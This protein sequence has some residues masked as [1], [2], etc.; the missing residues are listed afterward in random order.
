MT[1]EEELEFVKTMLQLAYAYMDPELQRPVLQRHYG[2]II[3]R[4]ASA[5]RISKG[6]VRSIETSFHESF[7]EWGHI[8]W[9]EI[10]PELMRRFGVI[11]LGQDPAE[12]IGKVLAKGRI[13][14]VRQA[15]VVRAYVSC[16][17]NADTIGHVAYDR[18]AAILEEWETRP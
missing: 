12:V 16:T 5:K 15:E 9:S 1:A 3:A 13:R 14:G 7:P 8:K 17:T 4:I 2:N 6:E 18:L 11:R 10:N